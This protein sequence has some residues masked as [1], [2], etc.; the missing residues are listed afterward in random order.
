MNFRILYLFRSVF[1]QDEQITYGIGMY[2][3][4]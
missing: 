3:N 2:M 1:T 4:I